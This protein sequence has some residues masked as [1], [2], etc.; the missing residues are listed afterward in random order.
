[1]WLGRR[2]LRDRALR[3]RWI[4]VALA[5]VIVAECLDAAARPGELGRLIDWH[6]LRTWPRP[7]RPMFVLSGTAS[8]VVVLCACIELAERGANDRFVLALAT[9]GQL[10]FTLYVLHAIVI[11]AAV[12]LGFSAHALELAMIYGASF[13]AVGVVASVWWRRRFRDG[14]LEGL[15]RRVA[16]HQVASRKPS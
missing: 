9:T 7:A 16:D 11:L 3:Q 13:F 5:I 1:M 8:A 14:P 4:L 2:D 6:W 15:I 12:Q 10:A